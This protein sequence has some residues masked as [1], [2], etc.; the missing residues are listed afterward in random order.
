MTDWGESPG[1]RALDDV[2][3]LEALERRCVPPM[4][5]TELI[6][7]NELYWKENAP[8]FDEFNLRFGNFCLTFADRIRDLVRGRVRE[9]WP[10]RDFA[11][12]EE[13]C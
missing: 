3:A 1:M 6:Y 9:G 8:M 13:G 12:P 2:W 7:R 4:T 11:A 10:T 5:A